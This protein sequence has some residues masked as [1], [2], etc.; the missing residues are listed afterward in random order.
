MNWIGKAAI[1]A[2]ALAASVPATAATVADDATTQAAQASRENNAGVEALQQNQP[3]TA[4]THLKAAHAL[5]P[6]N[7]VVTRNLVAALNGRAANLAREGRADDAER[8]YL[9][10]LELDSD[11]PATIRHL[12]S[13]LNNRAVALMRQRRMEDARRSFQRVL[14]LLP[15]V[16]ETSIT[17]QIQYNYSQFL[18][19]AGDAKADVQQPDQARA[20]YSEALAG[21][22][23]DA[24]TLAA[25]ADLDYE[26]D[27]YPAALERYQKALAAATAPEQSDLRAVLEQRIDTLR[28]EMAI[29]AG[30]VTIRDRFGRF[31]VTFPK[32]LPK[33]MVAQVLQT[34]N[35]AYSKIGG[36]FDRYPSRPLRVK[37]YTRAQ[38]NAIQQ[39]PEWVTGY[40]DGKLRLLDERLAGGPTLLRGSIFHEYTHAIIH[41]M[42][43]E[44]VPSWM[45]EGLAQIEDPNRKVTVRDARNLA[46]RVRSGGLA[47][48]ADMS[49]PFE[50][51]ESGDRMPLV[52]LE[53]RAFVSFM[54][55]RYGWEKVRQVLRETRRTGNFDAAF[56][57]TYGM[58]PADLEK[59]WRAWLLEQDKP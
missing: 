55:E 47:A 34:L 22:P 54:V 49:R 23:N 51:N 9:E 40:F 5:E 45:H 35:E 31:Q 25:L 10:A 56:K 37:I 48:L 4:V 50:R 24:A 33:A 57:S 53:S 30:F 38:A 52:Y 6:G 20:L 42:A 19:I 13:F 8:D 15:Q 44:P 11:D 1:V 46:A 12:V 7:V 58:T 41:Q 27:E 18:K 36:D 28:K 14:S 21:S 43:G 17:R 32:D 59:Q 16:S 3:E 2:M 26:A 29:E 39:I